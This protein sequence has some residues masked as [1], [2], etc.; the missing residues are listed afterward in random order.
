MRLPRA[1]E[2]SSW[3]PEDEQQ[4]LRALLEN[5][6]DA[7]IAVGDDGMILLVNAEAERLTGYGRDALVGANVDL[8][9]PDALKQGH[10]E[11][12]R[13]FMHQPQRRAMGLDRT[14]AL[15]RADGSEFLV[16]IA[17]SPVTSV[18]AGSCSPAY[19]T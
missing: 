15:R 6:P 14:L 8:L 5:A 1:V 17:L 7:L 12:R 10:A 11:S 13:Q 4:W 18:S 19:A 9:V 16:D 2:G 3:G